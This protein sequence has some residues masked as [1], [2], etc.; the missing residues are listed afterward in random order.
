[1]TRLIGLLTRK[2]VVVLLAVA[3][4]LVVLVSGRQPWVTGTVDAV[5]GAVRAEAPGADAAP[6]LV[7]LSLVGLAAAVAAVTA[8]RVGRGVALVLLIGSA[9]GLAGLSVRA[10]LSAEDILGSVAASANGSTGTFEAHADPTAWPWITL[11][12]VLLLALAGLGVLL[13]HR[14]WGAL[15]G[16]YEG[17]SGGSDVAGTRGERVASDWERISAGEDPTEDERA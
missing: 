16:R 2:A 11:V 9:L 5:L 1:M 6:G 13:G 4:A 10:V 3:A 8:G 15:S 12:A 14:Q 17:G 7:A